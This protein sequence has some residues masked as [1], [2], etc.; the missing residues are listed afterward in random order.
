M[1]RY[2]IG[3]EGPDGLVGSFAQMLGRWVGAEDPLRSVAVHA[4]FGGALGSIYSLCQFLM[5]PVWGSLS[6]RY[7]GGA[8]CC[9]PRPEPR[10]A[11][12]SGSSPTASCCSWRA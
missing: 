6:D 12:V 7:A 11:T 8:S 3:Q 9:S 5:A 2:Y 10:S 1:L 4:F